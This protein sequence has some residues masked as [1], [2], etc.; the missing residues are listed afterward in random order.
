M[1]DFDARLNEL[2]DRLSIAKPILFG[3]SDGASIALIAAAKPGNRIAGLIVE[4]AHIF[5]EELTLAGVRQAY[6]AYPNELFRAKLQKYHG[7]KADDVFYSWTET[8]LSEDFCDWSIESMLLQ[9]TCPCLVIQG[10]KDEFGTLQ[11]VEGI[12]QGVAGP[13]RKEIIKNAGHSPHKTHKD[14][15][16]RR[17]TAFVEIIK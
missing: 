17:S 14:L 11:Q 4:A 1:S 6:E 16:L 5:V 10:E 7:T 12:V 9:I 8:W 15:T 13:V 3:H 2:L